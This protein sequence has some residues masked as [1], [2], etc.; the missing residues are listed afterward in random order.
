MKQAFIV[1]AGLTL[2]SRFKGAAFPHTPPS[3]ITHYS[4]L[5]TAPPN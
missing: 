2:L 1:Q 5:I 3:L 4:L